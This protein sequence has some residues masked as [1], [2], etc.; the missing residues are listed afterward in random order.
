MLVNDASF[1]ARLLA[2]RA[3]E[4]QSDLSPFANSH[5][6]FLE[7]QSGAGLETAA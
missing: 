5:G 4:P 2:R 1:D 6:A 3:D 7:G